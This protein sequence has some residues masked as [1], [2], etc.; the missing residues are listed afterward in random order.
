M[1]NL[2][3]R[4]NP[5]L[6]AIRCEWTGETPEQARAS[7]AR[8]SLLGHMQVNAEQNVNRSTFSGSL[9]IAL[10]VISLVCLSIVVGDIDRVDGVAAVLNTITIT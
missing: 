4:Y 1:G 10:C 3:I 7:M 9:L 8:A 6:V 2:V 5:G